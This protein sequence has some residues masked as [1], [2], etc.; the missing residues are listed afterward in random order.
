MGFLAGLETRA[1]IEDPKVPLSGENVL[2]LLFGDSFKAA[3]GVTVTTETA[4]GVPAFWSGVNF[5]GSALAALPLQA[6]RTVRG[7]REVARGTTLYT[8]LHDVVNQDR[9]TSFK[10]RK[11]MMTT[12]LTEGRAF[13]YIERNRAMQPANLWPLDPATVTIIQRD[14][15]TFYEVREKG[16]PLKTYAAEE[17]IDLPFIL[18]K[19]GISH[20][21]PVSTLKN[22]LGLA[23]ALEQYASRFFLNGGVPPLALHGPPA[24]T[25]AVRKA[26]QAFQDA[27]KRANEEDKNVLYMPDGH[28]L[29]PIGFNPEEGQLTEARKLQILEIARILMLPPTF[30][31]DLERATFTNSEQQDLHLVKHTLTQWIELWEQELN[32]KLIG[33]PSRGRFIEF[34]VDGLLRGDFKNRMEGGA[35]AVNSGLRTPNE[36]REKD[37]LPPKPGGD[38]LYIQGASV[39]LEK[40]GE[41]PADTGGGGGQEPGEEN[42]ESD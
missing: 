35:R 7:S 19:D 2:A 12:V 4:L 3:S 30:L 13:T 5:I 10:W 6:F 36:L 41:Q 26:K 18:Q 25:G 15:R 38:R 11:L 20:R 8:M 23:I 32:A 24:S 16:R 34:N 27:V 21:A 17:I 14:N 42:D 37:N 31:Q 40:A 22:A 39:P 29:K 28:E 9:F 1:S 33:F